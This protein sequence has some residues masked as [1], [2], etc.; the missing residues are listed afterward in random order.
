[1]MHIYILHIYYKLFC[2]YYARARVRA[3]ARAHTHEYIHTY[4]F[5]GVLW[6]TFC[7]H[8][9]LLP[10]FWST[11]SLMR[12]IASSVKHTRTGFYV[13]LFLFFFFLE[14]VVLM[15]PIASSD[16]HTRTGFFLSLSVSHL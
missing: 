8:P 15:R 2:I 10:T 13:S 12:P 7:T 5:Q 14:Y 9:A 1:M 3:C 6:S 16:K 4:T 11:L